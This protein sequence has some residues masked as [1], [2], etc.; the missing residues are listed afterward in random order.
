MRKTKFR[1]SVLLVSSLVV[2]FAVCARAN[3]QSGGD[4]PDYMDV[5]VGKGAPASKSQV[6]QQNVLALDI[7]MFGLYDEAQAKFQKNF[8]AEHPVIM[9]LFSNQGGKLTLYRPG[10]AP[11][12]APQ[13]P[14]RYQIYKSVGHSALAL[15]ELVGSHLGTVSDQ[16]WV[17]PMRAFRTTSQSAIDSLDALDLDT[18]AR[19][20]QRKILSSNNKFMDACLSNGSYTFA[21]IQQYANEEK[22]FLARNVWL[23]ASTQVEHWMGVLKGWKEMLGPDWDKTY[24]VS[25]TLYVARQNNVIFSTMAQF[26]GKDAMNTRLF[27]F[28]TSQFVTTPDQMLDVL[29]RT[30]ADRSVGQVFFGNYYLMDYELMGGDGRTAIAEEDKKYGIPVFL[31]PAVPFHSNEWPF[32]IDPSQGEGPA[33]I[34]E[35]K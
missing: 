10:K 15:F 32:R 11:L 3:A 5:I 35:I 30:V 1:F 8:L 24:G 17:G 25:N 23:G 27:L 20:N 28:E 4:L 26:F 7:A 13:V 22:P 12:E 31:P 18:D 34:Q 6:A 33:T 2:N 21:D 29:I 19:E 9:G 14:I 16:S